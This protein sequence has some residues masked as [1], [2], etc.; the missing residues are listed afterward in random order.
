MAVGLKGG[1]GG[2]QVAGGARGAAQT[3]ACRAP[4]DPLTV[5]VPGAAI[6][7]LSAQP[8]VSNTDRDRLLRARSAM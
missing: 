2:R 5:S 7:R 8:S 6:A 1:R 3:I 4:S